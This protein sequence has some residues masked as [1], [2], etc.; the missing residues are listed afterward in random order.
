MLMPPSFDEAVTR[1]A[2]L[3][4]IDPG[5]AIVD[6]HSRWGLYRNALADADQRAALL[7]VLRVDP[8]RPLVSAVVIRALELVS[9]DER[10]VWL[11]VLPPGPQRDY[12][13][14]RAVELGLLEGLLE[15]A[16]SQV[17]EADAR[18]WSP[19]LQVRLAEAAAGREV[20]AVLAEVGDTK[21][22]RDQARQR[23]RVL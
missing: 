9:A 2:T 5:Q 1:L 13:Q 11:D 23:L 12:A 18:A 21:R 17:E 20:L 4:E 14:R 16:D 7:Q 15:D 8:N 22:I 10:T 3:A 6:E 19:W